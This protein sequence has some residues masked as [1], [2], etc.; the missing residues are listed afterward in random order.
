M[1]KSFKNDVWS[2]KPVLGIFSQGCW[3]WHA[4][5]YAGEAAHQTPSKIAGKERLLGRFLPF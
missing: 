2:G 1:G 5:K 4:L 3:E